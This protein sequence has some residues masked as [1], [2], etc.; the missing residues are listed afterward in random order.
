MKII[1]LDFSVSGT[2]ITIPFKAICSVSDKLFSGNV[3][4]EYIPFF[5]VI[6]Y[7][8][9]ER[10]IIEMTDEKKLTVE[11]LT[12]QVFMAIQKAIDP[13]YLKILVDVIQSDAHQ[14]VQVWKQYKKS[15]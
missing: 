10:E 1:D 7:I 12:Y 3:I 9:C 14:P 15:Y 6:E 13:D 4:I 5:K 8:D 2:K 11:Q